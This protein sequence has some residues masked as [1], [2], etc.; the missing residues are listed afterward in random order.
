M[1][2]GAAT[3]AFGELKNVLTNFSID[4]RVWCSGFEYS[5]LVQRRTVPERRSFQPTAFFPQP[6]RSCEKTSS[7]DCAPSAIA[8][9]AFMC[10]ITMAH[11]IKHRITS[12]SLFKRSSASALVLSTVTTTA[13]HYAGP[14]T[15]HA[16]PWI[17]CRTSFS[18]A[19]LCMLGR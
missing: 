14:A 8:A 13:A 11:T 6:L 5:S 12:K 1:A 3:S 19:G 17:G 4:L 16:Y 7:T 18:Q 2:G 9:Y 15:L 10:R